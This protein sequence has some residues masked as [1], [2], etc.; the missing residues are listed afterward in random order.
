MKKVVLAYVPVIH[1]GYRRFF[2]QQKTAD[3]WY[4]LSEEIAQSFKSLRKDLRAL[5]S[6]MALRLLSA[7]GVT[8]SVA[9]ADR[10]TLARIGSRRDLV[11]VMPDEEEM[12]LVAKEYFAHVKCEYI[13]VFLRWHNKNATLEQ[14]VDPRFKISSSKR[15]LLFLE[16]AKVQAYRSRDLWRS[17]GAVLVKEKRTVLAFYNRYQPHDRIADYEGD[18][19]G[20]FSQGVNLELSLAEHAEA[21]VIAE[22]AR[23]GIVT[24]GASLYVTAFPCPPCAKLIARSGIKKLYFQTGYSVLDGLLVLEKAGVVIAQVIDPETAGQS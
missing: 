11:V 12:H 10:K 20:L 8:P 3:R 24:R 19:R 14:K 6:S 5:P 13:P 9:I 2:E 15:D 7:S 4:I 17:V 22:A 18:P 21:A 1:E 23:R 16:R